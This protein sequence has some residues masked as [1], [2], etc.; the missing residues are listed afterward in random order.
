MIWLLCG[1]A[2]LAS[3]SRSSSPGDGNCLRLEEA[4]LAVEFV[5]LGRDLDRERVSGL[6]RDKCA[7]KEDD[8]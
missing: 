7:V 3:G 5:L 2:G 8:F 1:P 6:E 4:L